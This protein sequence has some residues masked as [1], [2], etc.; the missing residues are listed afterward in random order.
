MKKQLSNGWGNSF[1]GMSHFRRHVLDGTELSNK[2][3]SL[4]GP[5]TSNTLVEIR[6]H[7]DCKVDQLFPCDLVI[8]EH[9]FCFDQ[10]GSDGSKRSLAREKFFTGNGEKPHET[11]CPK[12]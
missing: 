2:F 1:Y 8:I 5:D 9:C 6:P 4:F 7:Q 10:F 11:R 12:H 3:Q